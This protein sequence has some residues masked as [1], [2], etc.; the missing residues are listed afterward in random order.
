MHASRSIAKWD[1]P[2][3]QRVEITPEMIEA[4]EAA[5]FSEVGGADLGGFFSAADLARKV[6]LAM[7]SLEPANSPMIDLPSERN[8][9]GQLPHHGNT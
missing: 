8:L 4:G 9:R 3:A 5:V 2:V 6:F 1:L 7:K